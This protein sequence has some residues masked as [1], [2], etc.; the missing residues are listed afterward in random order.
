V[1]N[2]D[3]YKSIVSKI[4]RYDIAK[5]REVVLGGRERRDSV[6]NGLGVIDNRTELVLIHDAARPFIDREILSSV[7]K[8][9]KIS[10]AAIVGVPVK[11]TIKKVVSC[12]LSVVSRLVVE[13]TLDRKDLWEIQTPQVF[14]KDLILKAY[15]R[16]KKFPATDD[17][18]LV[19]RLGVKV[20]VVLGS[21]NNIKITT[22]EDLILAEAI[23][24]NRNS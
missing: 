19:E 20:S 12:Q 3:N 15:K 13:K 11:A 14:N 1:V 8:E 16:F 21:Y 2:S 4:R 7:I 18:M 6:I 9:A 17:A 23:V 24:K 22:P 5:I 10:Q